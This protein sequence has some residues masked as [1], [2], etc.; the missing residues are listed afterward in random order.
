MS[1]KDLNNFHLD[2]Q[3]VNALEQAMNQLEQELIKLNITLS[4]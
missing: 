1:L 4:Q 3:Q 2:P